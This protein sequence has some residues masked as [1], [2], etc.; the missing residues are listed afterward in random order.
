MFWDPQISSSVLSLVALPAGTVQGVWAI[1]FTT[2]PGLQR[3]VID[4]AGVAHLLYGRSGRVLQVGVSGANSLNEPVQIFV[5]V[6][7]EPW[8][9]ARMIEACKAFNCLCWDRGLP[10][11]FDRVGQGEWRLHLALKALDGWLSHQSQRDIAVSLFGRRRVEADWGSG[12]DHLKS[13]VRRLITR[14]RWLMG[15]GYRTL[16]R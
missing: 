3:C 16:L 14:G 6:A 11:G 15:G 10:T 1:A 7:A 12:S 8:Q 4:P 2:I 9:L 5:G 13:R